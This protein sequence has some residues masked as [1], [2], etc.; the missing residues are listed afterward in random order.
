MRS[1]SVDS[2]NLFAGNLDPAENLFR[3]VANGVKI[4]E[5][6]FDVIVSRDIQDIRK[7]SVDEIL[8]HV[9]VGYVGRARLI[10]IDEISSQVFVHLFPVSPL[11]DGYS[12]QIV[13]SLDV[14][15]VGIR[16]LTACIAGLSEEF[17]HLFVVREDE[18]VE[19]IGRYSDS[20]LGFAQPPHVLQLHIG[21]IRMQLICPA[22]TA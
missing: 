22:Q 20:L 15:P 7:F 4:L 9:V 18:L 3:L 21:G 6:D 12:A 1:L 19:L 17:R 11:G 10:G 2:G 13:E 16:R 8:V 14:L 5:D